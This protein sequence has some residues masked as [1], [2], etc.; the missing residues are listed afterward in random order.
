[1]RHQHILITSWDEGNEKVDFR[2]RGTHPHVRVSGSHLERCG[3][4][5]LAVEIRRL[6]RHETTE[7]SEI[8]VC[9]IFFATLRV[10]MTTVET[11]APLCV[12][13]RGQQ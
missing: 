5:C 9:E 8:F 7:A 1:M 6:F 13:G 3:G 12:K 2:I 4:R 11:T 10:Q